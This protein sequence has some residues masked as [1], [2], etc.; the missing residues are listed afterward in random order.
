MKRPFAP[1][2]EFLARE[3]ASGL[4]LISAAA[5]GLITANSPLANTY[6]AT[7]D[8][9]FTIDQ[10]YFYLSL[11]VTKF[12]NYLLMS[13][14]FLVVGMEIKREL[15]SG[16]LSSLRR[17]FAPFLAA[18]GGM[19]LPAA[20]YLIVAGTTNPDGWAVPVATDIALAIGLVS[21]MSSRVSLAL[22]AFLLALAVIDDIGAILIIAIFFSTGVGAWWIVSALIATLFIY[23]YRKFGYTS[24]IVTWFIAALV[25]YCL[26]RG[27]IH[28]TIAG[29]LLG[30]SLPVSEKLEARVHPWSSFIIVPI[31]A[32][33]NS[34][35]EITQSSISAALHSRIAL[36]IFLGLLLGKPI[37]IVLVS[38]AAGFLG[39]VELPQRKGRF[40]LTAV[41]SAAGVGFT[42][43][44]FIAN[45]AF[46]DRATQAIAI[47]A[48]I[49]ASIVSALLSAI[50]FRLSPLNAGDI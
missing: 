2:R 27:G 36:G 31:F 18:I 22:K 33:A 47:I 37:G 9:Q 6:F 26:Y 28:P 49:A 40:A 10:K 32:F 30:L 14:F 24:R 4:I 11:T 34:G 41:G 38:R 20:I 15:L 16:H 23:F 5:L 1:L 43:A 8:K 19:A 25:W 42:V 45:L 35:V 17:A 21:L 12:I 44:I 3:S 13:F 46:P 29:V 48:I 7:L 39:V 50:L